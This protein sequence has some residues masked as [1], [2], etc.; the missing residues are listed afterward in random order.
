MMTH[1]ALFVRCICFNEENNKVS[2]PQAYPPNSAILHFIHGP[3]TQLLEN[4][5]FFL[6]IKTYMCKKK[7]SEK[8]L[9][10]HRNYR[11]ISHQHRNLI[12]RIYIYSVQLS[13]AFHINIV[14]NCNFF[15]Y[16]QITRAVQC[17]PDVCKFNKYLDISRME[18][19]H[20]QHS[21]LKWANVQIFWTLHCNVY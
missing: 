20:N 13:H 1:W 17:S 21:R 6:V 15:Y 8:K 18:I 3:E 12:C 19:K 2:M 14:S 10:S 11:R 16:S 7:V 9:W 5:V 4:I